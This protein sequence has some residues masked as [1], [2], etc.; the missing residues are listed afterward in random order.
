MDNTDK[1]L[2]SLLQKDGRMSLSEIGKELGMSHVAVSKRLD[3][4]VKENLVQ[5]SAGVNSDALDMKVLFMGL[6]TESMEVTEEILKKYGNCPRLV[7]LAPVTGRYNLFAVL[8]AEDTFSLESILGT[9]SMRTDP[10]VRRSETWFGNSPTTPKY[11]N[12]DLAPKRGKAGK[13]PCGID[14]SSCRRYEVN[15]CVA[16]PA[17]PV[18]R[19]VLYASPLTKGKRK[20]KSKS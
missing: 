9:C 20:R 8:I 14:C 12:L 5:V 13:S 17:S 7:T 6:E 4:L 15:K 11:V 2:V 3:K 18:Y 1:E 10:G 16:C 19:G